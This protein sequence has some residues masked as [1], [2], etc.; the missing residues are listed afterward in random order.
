L[1]KIF[2]EIEKQSAYLFLYKDKLLRNTED[3]SINVTGASVEAVLDACLKNEPL[4]YKMVG[5][6][7]VIKAKERIDIAKPA[8]AILT[9]A[10]LRII[11]GTVR[12][13]KGNPLAGV[14][15]V[16]KGSNKGTSTDADGSFRID[17]D[18]GDVLE[19]SIVGYKKRSITVGQSSNLS[20]VMEIEAAVASEVVVVGY[21]TQKKENLTGAVASISSEALENKPLP[22]VGEVLRGV[23][24]NLNIELG[25]YGAEPGASLSFNIRGVGSISGNSAPLI[26]VDG[27]EMD[28]N[29]LT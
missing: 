25:A 23:S 12:D 6:I 18:A 21:G 19:L 16:V 27:V 26:L 13:D 3:V 28:I 1:K 29:N 20:V 11:N 10:P 5:K 2:R 17:A 7:I 14:S 24:P 4:S 9:E 8:V 15:V 22:N